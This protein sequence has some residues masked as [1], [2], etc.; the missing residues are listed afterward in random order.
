MKYFT[1]FF[2]TKFLES[3]VCFILTAHVYLDL[4]YSR[5]LI[6]TVASDYCIGL[7]AQDLNRRPGGEN[8]SSSDLL[9]LLWAVQFPKT[10]WFPKSYTIFL[11]DLKYVLKYFCTLFRWLWFWLVVTPCF[12]PRRWL[13]L[14]LYPI[15]YHPPHTQ[16]P[17]PLLHRGE[18]SM[19]LKG[20]TFLPW[21]HD[22]LQTTHEAFPQLTIQRGEKG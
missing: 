14:D 3:V 13:S 19:N 21:C 15:Q 16:F 11:H 4:L 17:L 22:L 6:I 8:C 12:L 18:F 10:E 5:S 7:I 9:G 1:F 2:D 20:H